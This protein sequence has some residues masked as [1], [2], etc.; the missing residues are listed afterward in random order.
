M[1]GFLRQAIGKMELPFSGIG[2][3]LGDGGVNLEFGFGHVNYEKPK[4]HQ[5]KEV[6][7]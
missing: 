7:G 6:T 3:I 2:K 4:T 5:V 1:L